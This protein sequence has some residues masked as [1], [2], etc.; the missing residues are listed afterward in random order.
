MMYMEMAKP[1]L[2]R[3]QANSTRLEGTAHLGVAPPVIIRN[4]KIQ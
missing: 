3:K 4:R 2:L 1:G